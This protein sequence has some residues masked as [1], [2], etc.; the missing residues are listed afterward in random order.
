[1]ISNHCEP[2]CKSY[3]KNNNNNKPWFFFSPTAASMN[4][5]FKL[6]YPKLHIVKIQAIILN[7]KVL[8]T[9]VQQ[10]VQVILLHIEQ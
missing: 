3:H 9:I 5:C 2:P 6:F 8:K 4:Y 7:T 1:M 10:S